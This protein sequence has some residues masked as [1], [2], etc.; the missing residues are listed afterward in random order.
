M[1]K[2]WNPPVHALAI[3]VKAL[4]KF[5][6]EEIFFR[7]HNCLINE[8]EQ[9]HDYKYINQRVCQYAYTQQHQHITDIQWIPAVIKY[10]CSYE[11]FRIYFSFFAASD[12]VSKTNGRASY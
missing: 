4:S 10:A 3:S 8:H 7:K 2:V 5:I 12:N 9:G 1:R 11:V 6:A